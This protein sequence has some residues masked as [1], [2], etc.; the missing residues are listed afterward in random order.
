MTKTDQGDGATRIKKLVRE[1]YA[2]VAKGRGS[3]CGPSSACCSA[4]T[5]ESIG[6]SPAKIRDLED[7]VASI[8]VRAVKP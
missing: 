4:S 5:T 8:K 7:S 1:A 2:K 6:T 3:C